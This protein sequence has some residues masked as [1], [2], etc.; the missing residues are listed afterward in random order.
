L[1]IEFTIK[2]Y[3]GDLIPVNLLLSRIE[4]DT[5]TL[6]KKMEAKLVKRFELTLK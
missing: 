6:M 4:V 3:S 5:V 1:R 2:N